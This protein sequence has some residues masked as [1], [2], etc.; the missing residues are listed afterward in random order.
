MKWFSGVLE[1]FVGIVEWSSGEVEWSSGELEWSSGEVEWFSE[2]Q[3][4]VGKTQN[5][6]PPLLYQKT[7]CL[8]S[9]DSFRF[10]HL[11]FARSDELSFTRNNLLLAF[12]ILLS[13][14]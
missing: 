3:N 9:N 8:F 5:L 12:S 10:T 4:L 14:L 2:A 1:W 7:L 13:Q 6:V 11:R